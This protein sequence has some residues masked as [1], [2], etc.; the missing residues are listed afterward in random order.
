MQ[1]MLQYTWHKQGVIKALWRR[2]ISK[3]PPILALQ[4]CYWPQCC[5]FCRNL[6]TLSPAKSE[7]RVKGDTLGYFTRKTN[8]FQDSLLSRQKLSPCAKSRHL[9]RKVT[10]LQFEKGLPIHL[11]FWEVE[12]CV[13]YAVCFQTLSKLIHRGRKVGRS[14]SFSSNFFFGDHF[15]SLKCLSLGNTISDCTSKLAHS[16]YRGSAVG[17]YD[18]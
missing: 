6:A 11:I 2:V 13:L 15:L 9:L 8:L 10:F 1:G 12:E 18:S 3:C 4:C 5:L 16:N 14:I 17:V 7:F